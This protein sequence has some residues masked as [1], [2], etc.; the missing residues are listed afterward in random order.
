M[1][2]EKKGKIGIRI[3]NPGSELSAKLL[4]LGDR[5]VPDTYHTPHAI[6]KQ[7]NEF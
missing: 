5:L 1:G 2:E 7:I 6:G 3:K 4:D